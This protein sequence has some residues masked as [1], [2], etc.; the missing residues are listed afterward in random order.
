M[1]DKVSITNDRSTTT[2]SPTLNP[3]AEVKNISAKW[4]EVRNRLF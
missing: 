1:E 3:L 2:T 4:N